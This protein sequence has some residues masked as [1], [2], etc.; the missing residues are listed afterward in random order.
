M[1]TYNVYI[2]RII[3]VYNVYLLNTYYYITRFICVIGTYLPFSPISYSCDSILINSRNIFL[4]FTN[5]TGYYF[6][7]LFQYVFRKYLTVLKYLTLEKD[8]I[9]YL[10]KQRFYAYEAKIICKFVGSYFF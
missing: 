6:F 2:I 3:H 1:H 10:F 5:F 7:K 8:D 9:I 4:L